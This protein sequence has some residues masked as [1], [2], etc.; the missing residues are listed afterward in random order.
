MAN[1]HDPEDDHDH[2]EAGGGA[3]MPAPAAGA[4]V[5][6]AALE[7]ALRAIDP[8]SRLNRSGKPML[9]FKSRENGLWAYG[10]T[11]TIPEDGSHWAFNPVSVH[12]G[13]IAFKS[14]EGSSVLG[15][16]LVSAGE[17]MPDITKLPDVGA[18][19][20]E[21]W[22]IDVKCVNGI[23]AGV[24]LTFKTTTDGGIKAI[25][26]L[27]QAVLDRLAG[28]QHDGKVVPIVTLGKDSYPHSKHG[29]IWYPVLTI[30]D[31]MPMSGPAPTPAPTPTPT[32]AAPTPSEPR[33]RRVA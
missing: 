19:W 13:Y 28:G 18:P 15:E 7:T 4:L 32:P 5:S 12:R 9:L 14:G 16:K 20:V 33:R 27:V 10:Q 23:D 25:A 21:E 30:V 8:S 24:E 29:R 17:A 11:K 26:G 31:W 1:D 3:V 22:T 6:L 2:E